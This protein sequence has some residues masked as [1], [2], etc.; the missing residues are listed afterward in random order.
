MAAKL[1]CDTKKEQFFDESWKHLTIFADMPLV[2][3]QKEL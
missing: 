2:S 1:S 3:G